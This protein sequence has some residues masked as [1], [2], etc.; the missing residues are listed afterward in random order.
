MFSPSTQNQIVRILVSQLFCH[1]T[2]PTRLHCED[3]ERKFILKYPFAKDNLG[4]GYVSQKQLHNFI[5]HFFILH[6]CCLYLTTLAV[7]V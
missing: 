7:M 2:K 3:L 6:L 4:N 5:N 1:S